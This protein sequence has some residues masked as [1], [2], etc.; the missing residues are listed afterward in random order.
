MRGLFVLMIAAFAMPAAAQESPEVSRVRTELDRLYAVNADAFTRGDMAT[1]MDLRSDAFHTIA[2]DGTRRERAGMQ[3]YMQGII[4]GISKW[5]QLTFVI[6]SL[7]VSGDTATAIIWQF[8]DRMGL[9]PDNKVH[10]VQT[11]VTQRETWVLHGKRWLLWRVDQLRDQRR[12]VDG[13]PG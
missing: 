4:N 7:S 11:W 12:L 8:L 9:R 3:E 13:K 10:R 5:N 6:D 1:L 2:A